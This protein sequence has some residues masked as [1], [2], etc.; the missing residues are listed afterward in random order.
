MKQEDRFNFFVPVTIEKSGVNGERM[1]IKGI[2]STPHKDS[3]E[4]IL[5]PTGFDLK[6]FLSQGFLNWNHLSKSD[7]SFIVGEPTL[8][9]ITKDGNL[10]IEGELYNDS[11]LAKKV[12]DLAKTLEKSGSKRKLGFSIEGTATE[13]DFVNPKIVRKAEITG[14]AITPTPVNTNTVMEVM[15]G[16]V[17][18]PFQQYEYEL[19]KAEDVDY[20]L[21]IDDSEKRISYSVDKNF[22]IIEKSMDSVSADALTLEDLEGV[23]AKLVK[24]V[25]TLTKAFKE[26]RLN[27]DQVDSFKKALDKIKSLNKVLEV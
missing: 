18:N 12:W 8:A 26:G 5:E 2:A 4:E 21:M 13:R 15:K 22:N 3:Q 23:R 9:K 6:R 7:P 20:I 17:S 27:E 10:Y 19:Q 24:S 25:E 1:T 11:P 14:C 16:E